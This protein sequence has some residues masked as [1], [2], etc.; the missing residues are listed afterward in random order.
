MAVFAMLLAVPGFT[1]P[2][3]LHTFS[4]VPAEYHGRFTSSLLR[5]SELIQSHWALVAVL[6]LGGAGL[7]LWSLSNASCQLRRRLDRYSVWLIYP[8][9][10]PL[11]TIDRH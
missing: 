2:R 6:A 3:L 1:V 9:L 11:D 4:S 8:Y 10:H 7:T 5:G